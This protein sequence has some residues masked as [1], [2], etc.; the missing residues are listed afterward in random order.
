[1]DAYFLTEELKSMHT[2]NL[3][4]PPGQEILYVPSLLFLSVPCVPHLV[5][6]KLSHS[7]CLDIFWV[8]WPPIQPHLCPPP[9]HMVSPAPLL[10]I[11]RGSDT[12][13]GRILIKLSSDYRK[14]NQPLGVFWCLCVLAGG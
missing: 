10:S 3:D 2:Y 4:S 5:Q 9:K 11:P 6:G 7:L 8:C 14:R 12:L 13:N 1:M